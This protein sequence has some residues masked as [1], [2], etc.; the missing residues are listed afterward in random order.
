MIEKLLKCEIDAVAAPL[1]Y[2]ELAI[3]VNVEP[4]STA[5]TSDWPAGA[6]NAFALIASVAGLRNC[7][8]FGPNSPTEVTAFSRF[9][10]TPSVIAVF[11]GSAPGRMV[12]TN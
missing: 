4:S 5:T 7:N 6:S 3:A 10:T 9:V 1:A 8:P 11:C 2:V 12:S